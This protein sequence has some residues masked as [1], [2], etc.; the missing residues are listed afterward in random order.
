MTAS[1]IVE[2]IIGVLTVLATWLIGNKSKWGQRISALANIGWWI[3]IVVFQ[4]WGLVPM[5]VFLTI[6]IVRNL[7]KWEREGT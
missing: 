1:F 6:V 2:S 5:E 4:H 3:Y 7:I